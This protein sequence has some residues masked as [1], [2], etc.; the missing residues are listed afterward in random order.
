MRPLSQSFEVLRARIEAR[1]ELPALVLVSAA[2]RG[3]GTTSVACGL[4][5]AFAEGGQ[6]TLLVDANAAHSAV[7]EELGV[8]PLP[9][10]SPEALELGARNGEVPRLSLVGVPAKEEREV[11]LGTLLRGAR[12]H[13]A[14]IV[15]DAGALPACS[16]ALQLARC[17]DAIILA[18]RLGRR[19][20]DND[21]EAVELAGERLIGVVTTRARGLRKVG[22]EA[23]SPPVLAA[24]R[25]ILPT[26]GT[27]R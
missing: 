24:R 5:R 16:M 2:E 18:V 19:S 21:G 8:R 13:F 26:A 23:S 12:E 6:R 1:A 7:A 11:R 20:S 22:N 25:A 17:A 4:A 3:D 15:V 10:L 14:V 27:V 9:A